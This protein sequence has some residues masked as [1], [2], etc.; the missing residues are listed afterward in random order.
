M[1]VFVC[2][3][4]P[5][6]VLAFK[7]LMNHLPA[8]PG[9]VVAWW[10]ADIVNMKPLGGMPSTSRTT[11]LPVAMSFSTARRRRPPDRA[12]TGLTTSCFH[13]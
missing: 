13:S 12:G 11:N 3:S 5:L 6:A 7:W 9:V 8:G 10:T 1:F 2:S 4:R